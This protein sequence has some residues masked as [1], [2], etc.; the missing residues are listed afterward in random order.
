MEAMQLESRINNNIAKID[1][2]SLWRP[3]YLLG[4]TLGQVFIALLVP[5]VHNNERQY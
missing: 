4:Q 2:V 3:G 1:Y 5:R